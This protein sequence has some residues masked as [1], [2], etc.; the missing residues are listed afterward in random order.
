M[1]AQG[2]TTVTFGAFPGTTDCTTVITGQTG[3]GA[4]SAVE[5]WIICTATSDHSADEH[6]VDPPEVT[7]GNIV[8]GT[9]FT[10]YAMGNP[11]SIEPNYNMGL[12]VNNK[13]YPNAATG[14]ITPMPY[15]AW[16][17]GWCW[18]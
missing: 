13:S 12:V 4:G 1:G 16:T 17:V 5:A 8:A 2:V 18:N 14:I 11:G 10:I 6:W 15:G 7:A 3:I 9:G